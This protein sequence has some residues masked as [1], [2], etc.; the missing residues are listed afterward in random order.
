MSYTHKKHK[1]SQN[2]EY[3]SGKMIKEI[4]CINNDLPAPNRKHDQEKYLR[5]KIE[6]RIDHFYKTSGSMIK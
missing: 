6:H 1:Y 3:L 2:R 5:H 4:N